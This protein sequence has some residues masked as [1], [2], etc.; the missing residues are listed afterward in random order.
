MSNKKK[1][2]LFLCTGNSAR[3]IMAEALLAQ[4]GHEKFNA[5]SAG[6]K[7]KG[8]IHPKSIETL[9]KNNLNTAGFRS[10]SWD[11]FTLP[12]TPE[13]DIV[14]TVCSNAANESCPVFPGNP[15]STHWDLDDPAREFNSEEEQDR[16]FL[17]IF[18][19]LQELIQ[20]IT[21]L[22]IENSERDVLNEDLN[23]ISTVCQI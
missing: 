10:K 13:I 22:D 20:K 16:E 5:F 23:E 15:L 17:K 3:S 12:D 2:V 7:P 1:N 19:K 4:L 21:K 14:I 11:E 8:E 18:K 9:N 6:S